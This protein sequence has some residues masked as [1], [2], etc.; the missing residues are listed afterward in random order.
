MRLPKWSQT[1][2]KHATRRNVTTTCRGSTISLDQLQRYTNGPFLINEANALSQRRLKFNVDELCSLA[3][4]I[5]SKSPVHEI[6]KME[7]D[8][9]KALLLKK[10]DGT[11]LV[12]KLPFKI[13]G[14]PHYATASEVAVL[15]YVGQ[16][17]EVPV[18]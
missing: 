2:R 13:A 12:A 5:G 6:E 1:I 9:S 7:G 18:P 17:T 11:E 8:F 10:I 16:H 3:S 14:P 15:Q 4:K